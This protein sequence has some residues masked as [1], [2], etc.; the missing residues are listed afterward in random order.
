VTLASLSTVMLAW[1]RMVVDSQSTLL[2]S[3]WQ[4]G[5][6]IGSCGVVTNARLV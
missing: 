6:E 3:V 1:R 5:S 2:L 4:V